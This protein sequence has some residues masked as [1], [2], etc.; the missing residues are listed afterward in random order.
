MNKVAFLVIMCVTL[1]G[2]CSARWTETWKTLP[3]A[4]R[5]QDCALG[6]VGG[7][8]SVSG[9]HGFRFGDGLVFIVVNVPC[10]D[11]ISR[12]P[13]D[14]EVIH[15]AAEPTAADRTCFGRICHLG[16]NQLRVLV[17]ANRLD[18]RLLMASDE[19]LILTCEDD[20]G[21]SVFIP[22]PKQFYDLDIGTGVSGQLHE[23]LQRCE[24]AEERLL[25][26]KEI[27]CAA[28]DL[29][30]RRISHAN[31]VDIET[32]LGVFLSSD[33]HLCRCGKPSPAGRIGYN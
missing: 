32:R 27:K 23:G 2:C 30:A 1:P 22:L 12:V 11:I 13:S 28:G 3:N 5:Y 4:W 17:V 19:G 31:A 20:P 16:R 7:T 9:I 21:L 24:A 33:A 29:H 15:W 8:V 25:A 18:L 6:D 10:S 14:G 26:L